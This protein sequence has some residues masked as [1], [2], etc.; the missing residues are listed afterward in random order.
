MGLEGNCGARC[1]DWTQ[2]SPRSPVTAS[3]LANTIEYDAGAPDLRPEQASR[4]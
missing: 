1:V 2:S 4:A 3:I